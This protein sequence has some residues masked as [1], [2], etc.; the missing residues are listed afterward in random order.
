MTGI[1]LGGTPVNKS[2]DPPPLVTKE[3]EDGVCGAWIGEAYGL[4]GP[5]S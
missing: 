4:C 2:I 1:S 3:H 5:G